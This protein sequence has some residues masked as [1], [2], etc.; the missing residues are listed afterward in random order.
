M[1]ILIRHAN[2]EDIDQTYRHDY[3]LNPSKTRNAVRLGK[4]LRKKY[5]HPN[6]IYSSPFRRT[7]DTSHLLRGKSDCTI[8][9][10]TKLGRIFFSNDRLRPSVSK[11][12]LEYGVDTNESKKQYMKRVRMISDDLKSLDRED[13]IIWVVTHAYTFKVMS[14]IMGQRYHGSIDFLQYH[15][16]H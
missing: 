11:E 13:K 15:V 1:I 3:H 14:K 2:D 6:M 9:A 8:Y 5:G 10:S 4:K 12:T 16:F 7:L